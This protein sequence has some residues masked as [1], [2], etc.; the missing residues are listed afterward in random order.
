MKKIEGIIKHHRLEELKLA[1]IGLPVGGVTVSEVRGIGRQSE[2]NEHY[3][4][5]DYRIDLRPKVR[6]E[7][8]SD[9]SQWKAVVDCFLVHAR[10]GQPGDGIVLVSELDDAIRVRTGESGP[11][12]I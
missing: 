10:T 7:V 8:L 11:S 4:G 1:L 5:T 6:V 9:D 12:A 2:K 3:R